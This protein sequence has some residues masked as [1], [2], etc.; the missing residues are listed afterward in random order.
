MHSRKLALPIASLCLLTLIPLI[1][2][3]GTTTAGKSAVG[4]WRLDLAKSAFSN[5]TAPKFEQL[6]VNTDDADQLKWN[7]KGIMPDGRSYIESYEGPID[8]KD[9][10]IM[11]INGGVTA[12]Y[13][14]NASGVQWV[15]KDGSG[16]VVESGS[17]QLSADGNMLVLKGTMTGPKG[18]ANFVA[19]YHRAQ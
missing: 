7:I 8:G 18:K 1:A 10:K 16:T 17:A 6:V 11:A 4:T 9:H 12:A 19:V 14:R 15:T 3:A 13:T 5:T 2:F